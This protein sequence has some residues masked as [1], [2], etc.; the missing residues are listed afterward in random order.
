MT[1]PAAPPPDAGLEVGPPTGPTDPAPALAPANPPTVESVAP[2]SAAGEAALRLIARR[3]RDKI[4]GLSIVAVS[5][6]ASLGLSVWA[7]HASRPETSEPPGPP[8]IVG[9][10]GYPDR[11]DVVATLA[12]ARSATKRSILRGFV[13]DGVR[14]DGTVDVSEGPGRARYVFQSPPGRGPQPDV[15]KPAVRGVF[16]GRQE[17]HLRR[18]GLVA[19]PD[20]ANLPCPA[21]LPEPLPDPQCTLAT[22]WKRALAKGVPADRLARIEYFR[23]NAGPAWRFE[24]RES[25]KRFVLYGDCQRE[26]KGAAAVGHVP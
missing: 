6:V 22:I 2:S 9:V 10:H 18:E 13:A 15:G 25:G 14:S 17:V 11:I 21:P 24:A 23:A 20:Q 12:A 8:S 1:N 16:C 19:I 26:L 3:R 7:K 4:L 5:F